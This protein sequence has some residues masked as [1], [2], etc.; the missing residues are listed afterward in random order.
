MLLAGFL[1][2]PWSKPAKL[3]SGVL[4]ALRP[5][6]VCRSMPE[7]NLSKH[8]KVQG[9]SR[10]IQKWKELKRT[11]NVSEK[12]CKIDI[13]FSLQVILGF[14]SSAESR[15]AF[16][17]QT[18][19]KQFSHGN[20]HCERTW[21]LTPLSIWHLSW[22]Q[23]NS[24]PKDKSQVLSDSELPPRRLHVEI[25]NS[26]VSGGKVQVQKSLEKVALRLRLL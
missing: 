9:W 12:S 11:A 23:K 8:M 4:L 19:A 16:H 18:L 24:L 14:C 5:V 3:E 22:V 13:R 17:V 10:S 20:G 7:K 2:G 15:P 25:G 21:A 26:I 6:A 1:G